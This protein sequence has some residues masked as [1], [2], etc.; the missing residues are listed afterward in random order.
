VF[1]ILHFAELTHSVSFW[2]D[3]IHVQRAV[4]SE[5]SELQL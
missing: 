4:L 2:F 3:F 1:Y 5:Q